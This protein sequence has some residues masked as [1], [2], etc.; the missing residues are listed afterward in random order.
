M[1]GLADSLDI[2]LVAVGTHGDVLPFI[3]LGDALRARGHRVTVAAPAPFEAMT[4]RAGLGFKALGTVADYEALIREPDLWH[5]IRGFRPLLAYAQRMAEHTLAWLA[6]SE[7][8]SGGRVVVASPLAWGARIA[9]DLL[10]LP[11][12]TLHVMPFLI[13]SRYAPPRLPG[14]PI[15]RV[16]PASWRAAVNKG[17]DDV[18]IGPFILPSLNG[19][20]ERLGLVGIGRL[21]HWWNSPTRLLLM[22]PDWYVAPQEDWPGQAVQLGFPLADRFGDTPELP[23]GLD[24]FLADGPPPLIFT[25]GSAM[26]QAQAFFR[27]AIALCDRTGRRGVLLAPQADQ[28]PAPLP[29]GVIHQPYAPLGSLLPRSAALIHHGGI[30]TV[31][32]AL[33]AGVPQLIVPYAYNH[34]DDGL[35]IRDSHLGAMLSRRRFTPA[36]AARVLDHLLADPRVVRACG[37]ARALMTQGEDAIARAC[38][39]VEALA[40]NRAGLSRAA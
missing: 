18:L 2:D 21:R 11:T 7:S 37:Q 14:L 38:D 16:L 35:R 25:Y 13:E 17:V 32:Q 5:P 10:G 22:F 6:A 15:P 30:G 36:R 29:A 4:H 40:S 23:A 27:T 39:E 20:R 9:Q 28:I 8:R 24:A 31:A 33:A 3:A 34:F 1:R 12:A 19:L 26:R